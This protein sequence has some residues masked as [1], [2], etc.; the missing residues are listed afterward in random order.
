[1]Q[2]HG[3]FEEL[4]RG[5]HVAV[6]AKQEVDRVAGAVDGPVQVLPLA[7][8]LDVRL[9]HPPTC[10]DRTLASAKHRRQ[11]RQD[12]DRPTM[13]RGVIDKDAALGGHHLFDVPQAQRIGRVPANADQHHFQRVVQP[14]DHLRSASIIRFIPSSV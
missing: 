11:H 3:A 8:D 13:Y 14:L 5:R 7:T 12:L 4:P 6:S 1:V 10:A 9:V 2:A